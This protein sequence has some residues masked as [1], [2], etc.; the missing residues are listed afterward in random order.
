ME[1]TPERNNFIKLAYVIV[2]IIPKYLRKLFV[3]EWNNKYPGN[4]WKSNTVSG[5]YLKG[6]LSNAFKKNKNKEFYIEKLSKGNEQEWDT[7][8]LI[9]AIVYGGLRLIP[10]YREKGN[11]KLPL[12]ISEQIEI[13][14]DIRNEFYGH[15]SCMS[16]SNEDF[17]EVM[18]DI[19]NAAENI[20]G[21]KVKDKIC[22]VENWT[23][24]E[25]DIKMIKE[26][27]KRGIDEFQEGLK[28][29]WL[30]TIS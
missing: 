10:E 24:K 30:L 28:G 19:K 17:H 8:T 6:I 9:Q 22:E 11:R 23:M 7:T 1:L 13:L 2:E 21:V 29:E 16:L 4:E 5:S 25:N 20:F 14:K 12:R 26:L 27:L 15:S 3:Q 18:K